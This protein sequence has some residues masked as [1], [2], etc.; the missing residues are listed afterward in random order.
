MGLLGVTAALS[1]LD[2]QAPFCRIAGFSLVGVTFAAFV[3][4]AV[5]NRGQ[6]CTGWLRAAP[7]VSL[8][9]ICY[10][11]YVLQYPAEMLLLRLSAKLGIVWDDGSLSLFVAKCAVAIL[12]ATLSWHLFER[13]VLRLKGRFASKRHPSGEAA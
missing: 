11:V 1:G 12:V 9:K 10:G 2:R 6:R 8:G 13:R 7:L 4:W 3:L 5:S